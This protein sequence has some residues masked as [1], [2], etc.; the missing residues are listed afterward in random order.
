MKLSRLLTL[1][2]L[3]VMVSGMALLIAYRER[4]GPTRG[5]VG[6]TLMP[7]INL[8]AA[9]LFVLEDHQGRVT[10]RWERERWRVDQQEGFQADVR[11]IRALLL[12]LLKTTVSERAAHNAMVLKKFSLLRKVE[13]N[14][15]LEAGKTGLV[16]SIV[17]GLENRHQLIFR[18]IIGRE[19]PI[20]QGIAVQK[21][22]ISGG[23]YIRYPDT[24]RVYLVTKRLA[25]LTAPEAWID[26]RTFF[27]HDP[28]VIKSIKIFGTSRS[29]AH[30]E[31]AA[32]KGELLPRQGS[33]D[34][35]TRSE[36]K[37][38][39][40]RLSSLEII[41][42]S[43]KRKDAVL[44]PEQGMER[45]EVLHFDRIE[46]VLSF[47]PAEKDNPLRGMTLFAQMS[48]NIPEGETRQKLQAFNAHFS[49]W[50]FK[51]SSID[52]DFLMRKQR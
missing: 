15:K 1:T 25:W 14:W 36:R 8:G 12:T 16:I 45:I 23:T 27:G 44:F 33:T 51:V 41:R 50:V 6:Q 38:W 40:N 48:Q 47:L 11:K 13:N 19:R 52:A 35:W 5:V 31:R 46:Y 26:K 37:A 42:V 20:R 10:I 32:K 29:I 39:T 17:H 49:K 28:T 9:G 34:Q 21:K 3:L 30:L 4:L 24:T 43:G 2:V 22:G 18:I 7:P